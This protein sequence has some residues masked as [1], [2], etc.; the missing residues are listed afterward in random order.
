[1]I[2]VSR[3]TQSRLDAFADLLLEAN[4]SQNLIGASTLEQFAERHLLDSLQLLPHCRA[5]GTLL[6][7][8]SGAG[9]PGIILAIATGRPTT[10]AEPRRLRVDFLRH[11]VHRLGLDHVQVHHG[12]AATLRGSFD[13]IT[14][15]AVAALDPLL[16]MAVPL[17]AP[18]GVMV[19]PKGE[20]VEEE[21]AQARQRWH[22][23]FELVPSLTGPGRI[24]VATG[25]RRKG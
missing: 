19:F 10:L 2:E 20:R 21:L 15:R 17:L 6:D 25:V 22:G 18:G 23:D 4:A 12:K 8:G 24:V 3:E 5:D 9:L 13:T 16:A 7:I 11:A 1:M 14:A